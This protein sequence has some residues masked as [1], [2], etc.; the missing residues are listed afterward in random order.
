VEVEVDHTQREEHLV[1]D[2]R[3]H[4]GWESRHTHT[5]PP[6]EA[7]PSEVLGQVGGLALAPRTDS[8]FETLDGAL[9]YVQ[10]LCSPECERVSCVQPHTAS[11]SCH[12]Q[13]RQVPSAI[14]VD[15]EL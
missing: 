13:L 12:L 7:C 4:L 8:A 14:R 6:G 11:S 3:S 1:S 9:T 15:D 5:G 10:V 2:I